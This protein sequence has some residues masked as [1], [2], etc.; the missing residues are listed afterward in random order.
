M[1]VMTIDQRGS[2][3][4]G[5]RVPELLELLSAVDTKLPFQRSVG[6]EVQGVLSDPSVVVDTVTQVLRA[7]GWYIGVG[8][9]SVDTPLPPN[10]RE[11]SGAAFVAA[12]EAVESAKKTGD[13]VPLRICLAQPGSNEWVEAA[14]A[15][16]VLL[17]DIVRRRSDAEWRVL[18]ALEARPS[19][20]QK[21]IAALLEITP[22]AVS[23]AIF[24]SGRQEEQQ[25]RKAA[26][27]LLNQAMTAA[28]VSSRR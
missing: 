10:S 16:L 15:V 5:D 23:K 8:V 21:N 9:G 20:S 25:G 18:D 3:S 4:H 22:Q 24:R 11:A 7:K 17:G 27:L 2:R 14:Q 13:R 12:R 26:T 1:F 19:E 6:D 28:N